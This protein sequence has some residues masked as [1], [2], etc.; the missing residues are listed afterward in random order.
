MA[1]QIRLCRIDELPKLKSFLR[2]YWKSNHIFLRNQGLLNWQHMEEKHYNFV[3]ANHEKTD[4]FHGVLGFISPEFFSQGKVNSSEHIWLA[5]WKV[6]K[7]L[8]VS[9]SIGIDLLN[10]LKEKYNPK[11]I[12][13]IGINK[14]VSFVYRL[15]GFRVGKL[16]QGFILN[17]NIENFSIAQISKN[18]Y[19]KVD[20]QRKIKSDLEILKVNEN[21]VI[22]LDFYGVKTDRFFGVDYLKKRYIDHPCYEY[23]FYIVRRDVSVLA[24]FISRVI[25]VFNSRCLRIVD[26]WGLENLDNDLYL[27]FKKLLIRENFEYV[28]VIAS[29]S[30]FSKLRFVGFQSN[31][32]ESFV[33]HLFEP[34]VISRSEVMFATSSRNELPMFKA[35][36]DLDRPNFGVTL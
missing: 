9:K 23:S 25:E 16:I 8:T 4:E 24:L 1:Y 15:L 22:N 31:T 27:P 2:L 7:T 6:E 35:D 14:E 32:E 18:K 12:S 36:S 19:F 13:A 21:E 11:T 10:F 5:I 26:I 29:P 20:F 3:V 30:D 33:P 28:D 34:L 17:D